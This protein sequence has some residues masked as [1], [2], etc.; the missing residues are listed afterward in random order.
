[1]EGS[2]NSSFHAETRVLYCG[3]V[4][5]AT[6]LPLLDSGFESHLCVYAV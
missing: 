1:M 6:A 2:L 3:L 5:S 4:V